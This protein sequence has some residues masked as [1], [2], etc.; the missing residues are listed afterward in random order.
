MTKANAL[1]GKTYASNMAG[2][3]QF[4]VQYAKKRLASQGVI[5]GHM[6]NHW[7]VNIPGQVGQG[8]KEAHL[9]SAMTIARFINNF[10]ADGKG[11]VVFVEKSDHDAGHKPA[12]ENWLWDSTGYAKFFLWTKTIAHETNLPI[13]GWQVSEGNMGNKK[14]WQDNAAETFLANPERWIDGG[15][16]GILFGAGNSDC[17]NFPSSAANSDGG[18]FDTKMTEYNKA[19]TPLTGGTTVLRSLASGAVQCL[20]VR[21]VGQE[22]RLLGWTGSARVQVRTL[23]GR[24]LQDRVQNSAQALQ[25]GNYRGMAVVHI[26]GTTQTRSGTVFIP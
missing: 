11:D 2:W 4:M 25:L 5:V 3:A 8:R 15:F 22:L 20:C 12:N 1:S 19:P 14:E 18:W 16:I 24:V 21:R 10:G 26:L 17:V 23:D 13:V 7:G 6:P 9:I